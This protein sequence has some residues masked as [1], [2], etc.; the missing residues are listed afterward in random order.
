MKTKNKISKT[1][2]RAEYASLGPYDSEFGLDKICLNLK[3]LPRKDVLFDPNNHNVRDVRIG[4]SPSYK[5]DNWITFIPHEDDLRSLNQL[6][7]KNPR[8]KKAI[9]KGG[10]FSNFPKLKKKLASFISE[11]GW[12]HLEIGEIEYRI[13]FYNSHFGDFNSRIHVRDKKSLE[14]V[15]DKGDESTRYFGKKPVVQSLYNKEKESGLERY[16]G[17]TRFETRYLG[18]ALGDESERRFNNLEKK[19]LSSDF[20]PFKNVYLLEYELTSDTSWRVMVF[21]ALVEV[22]GFQRAKAYFNKDR[23]FT[24]DRKRFFTDYSEICLGDH[25]HAEMQKYFSGK[26]V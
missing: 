24:R 4:F 7:L 8:I 19:S 13:D 10:R 5:V 20:N 26:G 16:E 2:V 11:N 25:Y 18:Y 15:I 14:R 9:I 3:H 17:V 21:K 23:N 12:P 6:D 1:I 22:V